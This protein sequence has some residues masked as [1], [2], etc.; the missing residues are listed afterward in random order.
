MLLG[1]RSESDFLCKAEAVFVP[2]QFKKGEKRR[3]VITGSSL[4]LP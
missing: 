2:P 1:A 4:T 3:L